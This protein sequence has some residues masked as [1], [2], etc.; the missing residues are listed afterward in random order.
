MMGV[1]V[2]MMIIYT[3]Y[4]D[5]HS[6]HSELSTLYVGSYLTDPPLPAY[7][8]TYTQAGTQSGHAS[9]QSVRVQPESVDRNRNSIVFSM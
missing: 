2:S 1:K 8:F 4:I 9:P 3:L 5:K 6:E 7:L